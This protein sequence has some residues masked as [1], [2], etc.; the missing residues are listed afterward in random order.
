LIWRPDDDGV[1]E[2]RPK[3]DFE[4]EQITQWRRQWKSDIEPKDLKIQIEELKTQITLLKSRIDISKEE[5][6]DPL[7][8]ELATKERS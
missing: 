1:Q 7:R 4:G 3:N 8:Q 5:N 2:S 6:V